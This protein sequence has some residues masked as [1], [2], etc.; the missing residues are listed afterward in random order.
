MTATV[1]GI[2]LGLDTHANRPAANT[3]PDGSMYSCST[4]GLIYKSNYAGN[5]WS[6][7]ATLG[8]AA[9]T[10]ATIAVSDVT[11]NN[12]STSA[13]GWLKK[14]SNSATEYMDG[15]GAWST[16]AGGSGA[17]TTA[18]YVTTAAD[19]GLSAEVVRPELADL[20]GGSPSNISF[21]SPTLGTGVTDVSTTG[22]IHPKWTNSSYQLYYVASAIGTGDFDVRA[23]I[24][25]NES[26]GATRVT[27]LLSFAVTDSSG[28]TGTALALRVDGGAISGGAQNGAFAN[29]GL[30][31]G[32]ICVFSQ[33]PIVARIRRTGTTVTYE[34]STTEG[35]VWIL[36]GTTTSSLN[37]ARIGFILHTNGGT[38][39]EALV[40]WVR[41]Y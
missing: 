2:H 7:W 19:G 21:A 15:T 11:T 16:P 4:H 17:P 30:S 32:S 38:Q 39:S 1:A 41:S 14:L 29:T 40:A 9:V 31:A 34:V 27:G 13:H 23:R 5:S 24:V 25:S 10:D 35:G 20:G 28:T 33:F 6:T 37:I 26:T 8:G 22:F 18:P 12:A 36:L 3:A